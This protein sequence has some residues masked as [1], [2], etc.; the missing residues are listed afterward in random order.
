MKRI[1][2]LGVF[3]IVALGPVPVG[4][5]QA[6]APTATESVDSQAGAVQSLEALLQT[7]LSQEQEAARVQQ[8]LIA[9]PDDVTRQELADR[10]K[11]LRA[12]VEESRRQFERF[13]V[14]I[15]L[16]PFVE[17]AKT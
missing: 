11:E 16:S 15:D 4:R 3:G 9:A 1:L 14:D 5:G 12:E 7:I 6:D 10:L 8:Q 13:A 17:E 2:W